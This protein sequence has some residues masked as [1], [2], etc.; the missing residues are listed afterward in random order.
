MPRT[1]FVSGGEKTM[2]SGAPITITRSRPPR[3]D[4]SPRAD[5]R[6][7]PIRSS[8]PTAS[9][10]TARPIWV[11]MRWSVRADRTPL[12]VGGALQNPLPE[13]GI[14]FMWHSHNERE[15]TTDNVFP[16]GHA[17]DD[18]GRSRRSGTST[19]H[20]ES[21]EQNMRMN[22]RTLST[23]ILAGSALLLTAGIASAQTVSHDGGAADDDAVQRRRGADVGLGVR[24]RNLGWQPC[25]RLAPRRTAR[26][27]SYR[28][29]VSVTVWQPPLIT[30]PCTA[31]AA[32]ATA[33]GTC[34]AA[35]TI[36]LTNALPVG[37]FADDRRA[38]AECR[39]SEW[40]WAPLARSWPAHR[41]CAWRFRPRPPG[42]TVVTS[43]API[44]PPPHAGQPRA[45]VRGWRQPLP[46]PSP[47]PG[48]P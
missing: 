16:G 28:P 10:T 45:R 20:C 1:T 8:P 46:A 30:V 32:T 18:A 9:G 6:R 29:Q 37:D 23:A 39:G 2:A 36:N 11:P 12:P 17:D 40:T 44:L 24:Y 5:R 27:S 42:P 26:R 22:K 41:W 33:A 38:T 7:C 4:R 21:Q 25:Q 13:S 35:L 14:A 15:I 47:I 19:K 48:A 34:T 3:L 43:Q 31:A